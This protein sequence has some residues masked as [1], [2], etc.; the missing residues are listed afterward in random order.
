[1]IWTT[2]RSQSSFC[3][4]YRA[5]PPD[6]TI[7]HLVISM[8]RVFSCVVG[9]GC[10]LWPVHSFGRTLLTFALLHSVLQG[11]ICLLLQV[12]LNFLHFYSSGMNDCDFWYCMFYIMY[13]SLENIHK[14]S[15]WIVLSNKIMNGVKDYS[16][17]RN[18]LLLA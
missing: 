15:E 5:F 13:P 12:F 3:W 11:H 9:K 4:L 16:K 1:M 2:V 18:Q 10:L 14:S 7:D 6:F 17:C 8:C